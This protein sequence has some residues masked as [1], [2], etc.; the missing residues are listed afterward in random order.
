MKGDE[1][2]SILL[3]SSIILSARR[4]ITLSVEHYH[5]SLAAERKPAEGTLLLLDYTRT[6][7]CT[8][9]PKQNTFDTG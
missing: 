9:N 1:Q 7:T 3:V 8:S 4:R 5:C 2:V 6:S